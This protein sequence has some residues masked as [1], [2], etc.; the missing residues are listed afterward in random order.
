MSKLE[1]VES[2]EYRVEYLRV[3]VEDSRHMEDMGIITM[4]IGAGV[5]ALPNIPLAAPVLAIGGALLVVFGCVKRSEEKELF[6]LL[7][8]AHPQ[9]LTREPKLD[10]QD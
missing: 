2:P 10:G 8:S 1:P 7:K 4:A 6:R 3:K 9:S 5:A